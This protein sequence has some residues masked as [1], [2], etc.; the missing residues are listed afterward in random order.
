MGC[1]LASL[2]VDSVQF[3][4]NLGD[5][6]ITEESHVAGVGRGLDV[7]SASQNSTDAIH[8]DAEFLGDHTHSDQFRR[9]S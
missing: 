6:F 7:A 1:P 8:V 4:S 3:M 5:R 9:V 2:S